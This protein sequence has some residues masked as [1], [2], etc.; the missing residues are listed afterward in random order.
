M[1][2]D[3]FSEQRNKYLGENQGCMDSKVYD[4]KRKERI[5]SKKNKRLSKKIRLQNTT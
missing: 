3:E 5:N 2:Q 1:E 4:F